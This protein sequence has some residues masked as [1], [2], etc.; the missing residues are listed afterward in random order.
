LFR[1]SEIASIL[2]MV[3]ADVIVNLAPQGA[4]VLPVQVL[5]WD[6]YTRLLT[7]GTTALVMAA[8]SAGAKFLIHTS[9]AF[10]YGDTHGEWV[11][12]HAATAA[13]NPLFAAAV[14]AEQAVL[15]AEVPGCVLRVGYVYGPD[16][17]DLLAFRDNLADGASVMVGEES[18]YANWIHAADLAV[19]AVLAAE[20]QTAGEIF[21]ITDDHPISPAGFAD[22]FAAVL[23]VGRVA[24]RRLPPFTGNLL[25]NKM[26]TA[27]LNTSAR[28]KN[29]KAKSQLGWVPKYP[30]QQPGIEQ[31]LLAWRAHE[32]PQP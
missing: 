29:E 11:D 3:N 21:N 19:A 15:H 20:K 7:E 27:L 30:Q 18:H 14:R 4:N 2:K 1:A 17:E 23:G 32:V 8:K 9:Y 13:D 28:A 16:N 24:R 12:E 22:E 6:Y 25:A 26:Q 10:L 31:T 5:D